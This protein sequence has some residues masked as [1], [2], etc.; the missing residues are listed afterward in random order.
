VGAQLDRRGDTPSR[1]R[2]N[3]IKPSKKE[4]IK[5]VEKRAGTQNGG[6]KAVR[7]TEKRRGKWTRSCKNG[8]PIG[9]KFEKI[10]RG[11]KA[12]A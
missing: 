4:V 7:G 1:R 3:N 6:K 12:I 8:R 5:E 2:F 9:E 10:E 11:C